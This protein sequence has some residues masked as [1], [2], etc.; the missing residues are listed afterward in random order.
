MRCT[1]IRKALGKKKILCSI[2]K[3]ELNPSGKKRMKNDK[4][5]E[6]L[7]ENHRVRTLIEKN[8]GTSRE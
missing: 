2:P 7:N 8:E 3:L 5:E 4:L 6:H 1:G